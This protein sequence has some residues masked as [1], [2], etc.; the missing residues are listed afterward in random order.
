M[1]DTIILIVLG[2]IILVALW[3]LVKNVMNLVIN[4]IM[5]LILLIAVNYLHLLVFLGKTDVPVN[6]IT[7]IV[8][9]L[10]GIPGAILLILLHIVGLY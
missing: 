9:A 1:I 2:L 7:V 10:A 3:H 6:I 5:G 8:C 4:S